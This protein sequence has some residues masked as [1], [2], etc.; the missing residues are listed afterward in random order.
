MKY[1]IPVIAVFLVF[2]CASN[3]RPNPPPPFTVD[4]KANRQE[5][6]EI[7]GYLESVIPFSSLV[8]SPIKIFYYPVDDAVCLQFKAIYVTYNQFWNKAGRDIFRSSLRL[9]LEDYEQRKLTN[10]NRKNRKAY[11]SANGFFAWKLTP[12]S[13]QAWS[14]PTID[15]GYQFKDNAVFFTIAQPSTTYIDPTSRDSNQ[16]IQA[17]TIYFTRA[18]AEKLAELFSQE[19]LQGFGVKPS[20]S[21]DDGGYREAD[22]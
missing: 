7:D 2:S 22:G 3:P 20:D 4:L 21:T 17:I 16:T 11:G 9:Y 8:K 18:Q 14:N 13:V 1:F 15:I 19:N 5:I 6:D 12:V 10:N